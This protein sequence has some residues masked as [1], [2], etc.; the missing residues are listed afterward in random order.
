[1][2]IKTSFPGAFFCLVFS[3]LVPLFSTTDVEV[4]PGR[5]TKPVA[6]TC[7][8]LRGDQKTGRFSHHARLL[9]LVLSRLEGAAWGWAEEPQCGKQDEL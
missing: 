9:L 6:A 7:V 5:F 2:N 3:P 8:V 1:M 4:A